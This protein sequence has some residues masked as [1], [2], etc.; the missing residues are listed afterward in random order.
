MALS[1]CAIIAL[2]TE[3]RWPVFLKKLQRRKNGKEHVYWALVESY[4]TPRGPR[5][6]VVAYLGELQPWC[7]TRPDK[8]QQALLDR[9]RLT[10]PPRLGRPKWR[11][12]VET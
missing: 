10:L 5:N 4:R 3:G 6:R 2:G 12:L 8:W 11:K 7:V 9:L 1:G